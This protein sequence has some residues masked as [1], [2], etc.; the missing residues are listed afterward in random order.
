[1]PFLTVT[2]AEKLR[3]HFAKRLTGPLA[4]DL[5]VRTEGAIIIPGRKQCPTCGS[6]KE[7]LREIARLS[8]LVTLNVHDLDKEQ[9]LAKTLGIVEAPAFVIRGAAKGQLRYLGI[10]AGYELAALIEDLVDV[11]GGT[12]ALSE[13]TRMALRN[14]AA[15]VTIRVFVTPTCPFC[16]S[17]AR[18]AH[19]MA[20][21]SERVTAEVVEVG[22][23]EELGNRY[24]VQGVPKTVLNETV[25]LL[26]AQPEARFLEAVLRAAA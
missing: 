20:V 8:D 13:Q 24:R 2:E 1:M 9:V 17:A 15:D 3:R 22:E 11:S 10:P 14:L 12:T 6:T 19:K 7:L 25:E 16:P 4:I 18:L 21:E 5:F 23:F 26:G